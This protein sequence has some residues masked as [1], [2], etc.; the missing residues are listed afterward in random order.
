MKKTSLF[1]I[2]LV[3]ILAVLVVPCFAEEEP[4]NEEVLDTVAGWIENLSSSTSIA[5]LIASVLGF[6]GTAALLASKLKSILALI[7]NKA[8]GATVANALTAS[9]KEI[10]A[11]FT[12]ELDALKENLAKSEE[13]EKM[14]TATLGIAFSYS[15]DIPASARSQIMGLLNGTTEKCET[16]Q[17]I[18]ETAKQAIEEAEKTAEKVETPALDAI[19]GKIEME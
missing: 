11:S 6:S 9:A 14:L 13:R 16:V 2:L 1:L 8:D 17:K 10:T 3:F 12:K 4:A 7:K 15:K 5:T 18:V 19:V